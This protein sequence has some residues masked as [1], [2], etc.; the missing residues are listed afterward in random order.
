MY[1]I[2][3]P[4]QGDWLPHLDNVQGRETEWGVQCWAGPWEPTRL[5]DESPKRRAVDVVSPCR[6]SSHPRFITGQD[7]FCL[8]SC[9]QTPRL[10]IVFW[11]EPIDHRLQHLF[12]LHCVRKGECISHFMFF[13]CSVS[14]YGAKLTRWMA[15]NNHFLS[16]AEAAGTPVCLC[17]VLEGQT[18]FYL[19]DRSRKTIKS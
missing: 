14:W 2:L 10:G 18:T 19:W 4:P 11:R 16:P 15:I 7:G 6:C 9:S 8:S 5:C 17:T 12:S 1:N 3:F 13:S